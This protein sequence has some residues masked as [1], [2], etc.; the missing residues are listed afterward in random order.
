MATETDQQKKDRKDQ[1]IVLTNIFCGCVMLFCFAVIAAYYPFPKPRLP[2]LLDRLVFTLRWLIASLSTVFAGIIWVANTRF[3]TSAINPLNQSGTKYV[4]I[5]SKYLQN[6]VEQFLL[7]SFS[8]VTLSTYLSEENMHLV[9]LLV[10][11][12]SIARL[13]FAVGYSIDPHK[14]VGFVMTFYP[15]IMVKWSTTENDHVRRA[16]DRSIF[17]SSAGGRVAQR[18]VS[19][20]SA[21]HKKVQGQRSLQVK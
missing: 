20:K 18:R 4:G 7:H 21:Q 3:R 13:L 12:S 11:L 19:S 16:S 17:H 10:V 5:R 14:R 2:T 6:T 9:P 15:T 1:K 8:L